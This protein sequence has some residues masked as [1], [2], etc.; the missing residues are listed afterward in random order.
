MLEVRRGLL[1]RDGEMFG[2]GLPP[3]G[4]RPMIAPSSMRLNIFR[5]AAR[6]IRTASVVASARAASSSG[7]SPG[8]DAGISRLGTM[9]SLGDLREAPHDLGLFVQLAAGDINEPVEK[10][11]ITG[12]FPP[13]KEMERGHVEVSLV[14]QEEDEPLPFLVPGQGF[15][16]VF[17]ALETASRNKELVLKGQDKIEILPPA[18]LIDVLGRDAA[19]APVAPLEDGP[20][21]LLDGL[22]DFRVRASCLHLEKVLRATERAIEPSPDGGAGNV[23][24]P[25]ST[26]SVNR[27]LG[28]VPRSG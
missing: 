9:T 17:E 14:L 16:H 27:V 8:L 26:I 13:E 1:D 3:S 11:A 20:E 10:Q 21:R 15:V 5:N 19:S 22:G 2:L 28:A 4:K 12:L 25:C 23:E 7:V 18:G 6:L 24:L